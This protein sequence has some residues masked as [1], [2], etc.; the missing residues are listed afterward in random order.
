MT[1]YYTTSDPYLLTYLEWVAL[2]GV[3]ASVIIA[4]RDIGARR[5]LHDK[6]AVL[7][8]GCSRLGC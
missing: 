6:G 7:A 4:V 1:R 3:Y 8:E 2:P 5:F